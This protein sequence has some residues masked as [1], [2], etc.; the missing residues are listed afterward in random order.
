M[1]EFHP[2]KYLSTVSSTLFV[3]TMTFIEFESWSTLQHTLFVTILEYCVVAGTFVVASVYATFKLIAM[4][5]GDIS[6]TWIPSERKPLT[7]AQI[8]A[9]SR[10]EKKELS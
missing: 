2:F 1:N 7:P 5:K 9:S 10:S 3:L 8:R 6:G 4:Y